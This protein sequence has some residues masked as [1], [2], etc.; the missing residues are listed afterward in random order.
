LVRFYG[1]GIGCI[2]YPEKPQHKPA[3]AK[4][5]HSNSTSSQRA[6]IEQK[7]GLWEA[8]QCPT[9]HWTQND[10]KAKA[11]PTAKASKLEKT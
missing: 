6:R 7:L 4:N 11:M 10:T 2:S 9:N 1:A 8:A 5:D 3:K